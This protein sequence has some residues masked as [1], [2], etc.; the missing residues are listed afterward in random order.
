MH[1]PEK[2]QHVVL[3]QAEHLDVFHD[4][5]FVIGDREQRILKQRFRVFVVATSKKLKSFVDPCRRAQQSF[6]L[7]IFVQANEH[8]LD[9]I[10][11]RGAG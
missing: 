10:L 5:H 11:E 7:R 3:A 2:W 8:F 4:H 9:Q 1:L 6:A